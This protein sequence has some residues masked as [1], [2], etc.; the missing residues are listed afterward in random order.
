MIRFLL[1]TDHVSLEERGHPRV[2]AR[3]RAESPD[4]LAVS[5]VTVEEVIRGR[6]ARLGRRLPAS[7]LVQAYA[8]FQRAVLFFRS[9]NIIAFDLDSERKFQE[10]RALRLRIGTLDLRIAAT[11]LV[12][13]LTLVTRN[14]K[15]FS[16][17]PGLRIEDWS[18]G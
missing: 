7:K 15:D 18:S 9:G 1:D 6:M 2:I 12:H 8:N 10:L 11:T 14:H 16:R 5:I 13:D 17:V 4:S 3:V